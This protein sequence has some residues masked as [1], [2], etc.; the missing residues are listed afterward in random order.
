MHIK[1]KMHNQ[2]LDSSPC[3]F[4]DNYITCSSVYET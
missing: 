1:D 3:R 4:K 2:T